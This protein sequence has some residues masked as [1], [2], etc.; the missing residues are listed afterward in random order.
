MRGWAECDVEGWER[1]C[2]AVGSSDGVSCRCVGDKG[3]LEGGVGSDMMML[4]LGW[5]VWWRYWCA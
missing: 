1:D 4:P 3:L 5:H 2:E